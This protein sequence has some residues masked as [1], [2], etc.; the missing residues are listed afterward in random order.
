M[1]FI[2][3]RI[4]EL[5]KIIVSTTSLYPKVSALG[6]LQRAH[7]LASYR[8]V[9]IFMNAGGAVPLRLTKIKNKN[10]G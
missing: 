1:T 9:C 8:S 10:V 4:Q 2:S 5:V 7:I 6:L 3:D